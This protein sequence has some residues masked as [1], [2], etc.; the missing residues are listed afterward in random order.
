M[1]EHPHMM[2]MGLQQMNHKESGDL[3]TNMKMMSSSGET[4]GTENHHMNN[5][6]K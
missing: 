5:M 3:N 4:T 6:N 1:S 2:M